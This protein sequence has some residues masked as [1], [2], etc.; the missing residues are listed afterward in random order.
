MF[1][2]GANFHIAARARP[3]TAIGSYT[4]S[5]TTT[6]FIP[7]SVSE[8][9]STLT[10]TSAGTTVTGVISPTDCASTYLRF[11]ADVYRVI[12]TATT[13]VQFDLTSTAFTPHL[14][15]YGNNF[16]NFGDAEPYLAAGCCGINGNNRLLLRPLQA[17]TYYITVQSGF[18]ETGSYSLTVR[19]VP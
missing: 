5:V 3:G 9:I 12:V 6:S 17:G 8:P 10:P 19:S 16:G 4:L 1:F 2:S 13:N 7:C 11:F 18:A 14:V 15:L